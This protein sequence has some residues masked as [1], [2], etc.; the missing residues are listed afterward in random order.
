MKEPKI[1]VI[2]PVYKVEPYLRK[3][4]DSIVNQ[5]YRNL[6]IILVDDGS[7][8]NCGAICDEYAAKDQRVRVIHKANGGL[9]SARNAAL[10]IATGDYVGFV[11][12]DDWIETDMFEYLLA[13]MQL[14]KAD[15]AV[16][17]V[18][19]EYP[20]HQNYR[21]LEKKETFDR[22]ESMK[23]LL[24]GG[25]LQNRVWD[26]LWRRA[27]FTAIRFPQGKNYEDLAIA[28]RLFDKAR[29]LVC[30]PDAKYH[31]LLRGDSILADSSLKNRMDCYWAAKERYQEMKDAW[32]QYIELL[33]AQC[34]IAAISVWGVYL[35][36]PVR[37]RNAYRNE[38]EEMST[39]SRTHPK[40]M[41]AAAQS[42]GLAGRAVLPLTR[43]SSWWAFALAGMWSQIF[44][45]RHRHPL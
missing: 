36:N 40:G 27:L 3:C 29:K 42:L 41:T 10:E 32:P 7:P 12:S 45:L 9:S 22:E 4:L 2:V 38:I 33:E 39:F 34:M 19:E 20:R 37:E 25:M 23:L 21:A 13:G 8:D 18:I 43:Y 35:S 16:C 26:K 5:T 30:L 14:E 44:R 15:V 24:Q 1:S 6:E 17:G 11:D 28:H 31:Y